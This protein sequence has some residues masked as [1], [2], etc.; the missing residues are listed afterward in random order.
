MTDQI[1]ADAIEMARDNEQTIGEKRNYYITLKQ[2]Q[3]I[4][5]RFYD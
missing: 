3:E 4:I 5:E 1:Y 2:L